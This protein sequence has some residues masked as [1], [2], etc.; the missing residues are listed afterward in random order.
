M[1]F[2]YALLTLF[3]T[4]KRI[5]VNNKQFEDSTLP[6]GSF[7]TFSCLLLFCFEGRAQDN[8]LWVT[9]GSDGKLVYYQDSLGNR[10]PD[11]SAVGYHYGKESIPVGKVVATFSPSGGDDTKALQQLIDS[12]GNLP[13]GTAPKVILL[14]KGIY[15][16]SSPIQIIHNGLILR[17][18]GEETD[19]TIITYKATTQS[20]LFTIGTDAKMEI[21]K[22]SAIPST[23]TYLPVGTCQMH[24]KN[25]RNLTVGQAVL[26]QWTPNEA[27]I[28]TLGMDAI[29]DLREGSHQWEAKGFPLAAERVITHIDAA[30]KLVTL[31]IPL[32]MAYD[33]QLGEVALVPY[34][35]DQRVKEVG[36]EQL[37]LVS[38][39]HGE[40][41]EA[42]GWCAIRIEAAEN[43]WVQEVTALHFGTSCVSIGHTG[44]LVTVSNATC[45]DPIS[46]ITGGRRYSFNCDGQLNL[47]QGCVARNGR[48]DFVT[49]ARVCGPNVFTRCKASLT[50]ADIGPHHRWSIGILYDNVESDGAINAQD[51]GNWGSGH[52]W[53]GAYQV[54]WNCTGST[55]AIQNPPTAYNWNIGFKGKNE[56][57][58]LVR[59]NGVW[60]LHN[61][62]A[63]PVSLYEA[64]KGN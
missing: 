54:F 6:I 60:Q 37:R 41:D 44:R 47:F 3:P 10:I 1:P 20:N 51:R 34:S 31:N 35:F 53:S 32:V 7:L 21:N 62:T 56:G 24:V 11:F 27:W 48:H 16:I 50:H 52:G 39:F 12:V 8:P 23:D 46:Q 40:N 33:L 28:H 59:P 13:A 18:S 43:C 26:V 45:L 36:V 29:A 49:G 14:A 42:H 17:G 30:K 58:K 15:T 57:A 2:I 5:L 9:R 55:A 38:T 4:L 25:T 61:K 63:T 64:Q 22:K 19:G